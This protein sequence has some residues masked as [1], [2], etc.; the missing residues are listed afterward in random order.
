MAQH[1]YD[2]ADTI[3]WMIRE[4]AQAAAAETAPDAGGRV[5]RKSKSARERDLARLEVLCEARW[6]IAGRV[7]PLEEVVARALTV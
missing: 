1:H 4:A 7:E 3:D 2:P 6:N 5:R